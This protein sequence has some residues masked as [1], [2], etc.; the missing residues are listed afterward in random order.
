MD[1]TPLHYYISSTDTK[2]AANKYKWQT[3][4][5][6]KKRRAKKRGRAKISIKDLKNELKVKQE[7]EKRMKNSLELLKKRTK[8]QMV[9]ES[10]L[11]EFDELLLTEDEDEN[12]GKYLFMFSYSTYI[13]T[14]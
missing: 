11:E 5:Y 9:T 12:D 2:A 13:L 14:V 4:L 1:T 8:D 7:C 10:D 3:N 6:R